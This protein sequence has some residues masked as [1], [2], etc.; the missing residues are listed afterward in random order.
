MALLY[1]TYVPLISKRPLFHYVII[2]SLAVERWLHRIA[3]FI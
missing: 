3:C 2:T 1:R